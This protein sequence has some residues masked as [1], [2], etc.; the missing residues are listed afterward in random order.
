MRAVKAR[1]ADA[2][3]QPAVGRLTGAVAAQDARKAEREDLR[4]DAAANFPVDRIDARGLDFQES[5]TIFFKRPVSLFDPHD[6]GTAVAVNRQ[7]AHRA[8][9]C[10]TVRT[11]RAA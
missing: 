7:G 9:G 8:S 6:F 10:W 1:I 4:H 3:D 11:W 2:G 5:K